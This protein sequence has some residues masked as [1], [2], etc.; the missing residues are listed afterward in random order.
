[1]E[2]AMK[3]MIYGLLLP[4]V[5]AGCAGAVDAP[6]LAV[7]PSENAAVVDPNA[8]PVVALVVGP[9]PT[10]PLD[11]A[12]TA[13]LMAI[14]GRAKASATNFESGLRSAR[15]AADKASGASIGSDAWI[16]AQLEITRLERLRAPATEAL[17]EIDS[18]KRELIAN[19]QNVDQPAIDAMIAIVA[20]VDQDQQDGVAALLAKLKR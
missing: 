9:P 18:L 12:A 4:L 15:V 16:A 3:L 20:K 17:A 13:R 2:T 8:P 14:I 11:G 10:T 7:R 19:D 1:M 6:S 5:L